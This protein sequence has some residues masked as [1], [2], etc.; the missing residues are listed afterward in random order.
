M[1][2]RNLSGVR[3]F[4]A[5]K[6]RGMLWMLSAFA[7]FVVLTSHVYA[8]TATVVGTVTDP[9]GA[10]VANAAVKLTNLETGLSTNVATVGVEP[11]VI[12]LQPG[13]KL[14]EEMYD[15]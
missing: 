2:L 6:G 8:R 3:K 4:A 7:F 10:V 5:D 15:A 11:A 1:T 9:T 12:A 14:L 13:T